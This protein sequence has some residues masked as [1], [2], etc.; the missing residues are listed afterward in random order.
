MENQAIYIQS[1]L[2]E[3]G[4][5]VELNPMDESSYKNKTKEMDS[6]EYDLILAF[7]TLGEEPSLYSD[8]V[9]SGR[10]SNYSRVEDSELDALWDKANMTADEEER[11]GLYEEIQTRINDN[12]YIYP[13]AYSKG[14]Y[15][16]DNQFKGFDECLL[17]TIYYDYSKIYSVQ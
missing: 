2:Q 14:F 15:A 12:T 8:M 10:R 3:A 7:Y 13:I 16:V 6:A 1:K 17:K 9:Y 5:T 11:R 4:I